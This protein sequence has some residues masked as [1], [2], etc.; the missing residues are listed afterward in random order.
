MVLGCMVLVLRH[1]RSA[2][3]KRLLLCRSQLILAPP[4]DGRVNRYYM[5]NI[6]TRSLQW[7]IHQKC[8]GT[9]VL[10]TYCNGYIGDVV[11]LI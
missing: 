3:Q 6:F 11:F 8:L 7:I 1:V 10:K 9:Q 2:L 5:E 4:R